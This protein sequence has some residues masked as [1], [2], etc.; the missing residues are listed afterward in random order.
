MM[1]R[2]ALPLCRPGIATALILAFHH[3]RN[4]LLIAMPLIKNDLHRTMPIGLHNCMRRT[5]RIEG[6]MAATALMI[7]PV[8]LFLN[9]PQKHIVGGLTMG[10]IK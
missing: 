5:A 8:S 4:K 1:L 6:V 3:C 10:F 9:V 7:I 2:L